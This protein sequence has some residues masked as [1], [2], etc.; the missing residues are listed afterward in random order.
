MAIIRRFDM[1]GDAK[2]DLS[3]FELGMKSSLF[4]YTKAGK[5]PKSSNAILGYKNRKNIAKKHARE[6]DGCHPI[7]Q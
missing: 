4:I 7:R 2:I 6:D 3:E 1:D 5:R